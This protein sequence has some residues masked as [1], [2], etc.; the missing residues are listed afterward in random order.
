[1]SRPQS[2]TKRRRSKQQ[3]T[4]LMWHTYSNS[5]S[6]SR[7]SSRLSYDNDLDEHPAC[8]SLCNQ[9]LR[10][11]LGLYPSTLT[12]LDSTG[13]DQASHSP[14]SRLTCQPTRPSLHSRRPVRRQTE[15][16]H[17][18]TVGRH[19]LISVP[20]DVIND[21]QPPAHMHHNSISPC[22]LPG[23][24]PKCRPSSRLES[25]EYIG[26]ISQSLRQTLGLYTSTL[27]M[28]I[29]IPLGVTLQNPIP[30]RSSIITASACSLLSFGSPSFSA[31]V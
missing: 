30:P 27:H 1:M 24:Y 19:C 17:V 5:S 31:G 3:R 14:C 21:C 16:R 9:S 10:Q 2:R 26:P 4:P 20:A 11:T 29:S 6:S 13:I 25:C 8:E 15:L 22:Q 23:V 18:R 12:T 28:R 7:H